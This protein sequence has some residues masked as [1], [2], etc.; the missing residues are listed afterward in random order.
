MRDKADDTE[1]GI[2]VAGII[3]QWSAAF[4]RLDAEALAA[5]YSRHAFFYGSNPK[6]YRGNEGVTAYFDA[7]PCWRSP[8]VQFADVV[9]ARVTPDLV[10]FA[11]TASFVVGDDAPPLSVKITWVIVREDG[12]WKI[13]SHHVSSRT[14]LL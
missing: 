9:T 4:N 3:E 8:T 5:L 7:L 6:L 2:I 12:G 14:P 11:G 13:V 1:S 10:N